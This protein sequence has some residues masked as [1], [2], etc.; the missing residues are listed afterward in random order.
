M[1]GDSCEAYVDV[2]SWENEITNVSFHFPELTGIPDV[3][4][5]HQIDN[6]WMVQVSNS[7]ALVNGMYNM[8]VSAETVTSDGLN[9]YSIIIT[10]PYSLDVSLYR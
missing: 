10:L 5:E 3:Y 7:A 4:F 1:E 9:L 8:L 2:Y 6:S